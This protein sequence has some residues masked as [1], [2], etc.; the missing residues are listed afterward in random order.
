MNRLLLY[1]LFIGAMLVGG[2]QARW[3]LALENTSKELLHGN[4][5]NDW[6]LWQR[7]KDEY[8][9]SYTISKTD[10]DTLKILDLIVGN[11][12]EDIFINRYVKSFR[13]NERDTCHLEMNAQ[14]TIFFYRQNGRVKI[15]EV[16][17]YTY[18]YH[19]FRLENTEIDFYRAHEDSLRK[20]K[21]NNLPKLPLLNK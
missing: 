6:V 4:N 12:R 13:C 5:V 16:G 8:S 15:F 21:G 11:Q 14:D 19:F 20:V 9:T 1:Q 3:H 7:I 17:E 2:C 18:R 10:N